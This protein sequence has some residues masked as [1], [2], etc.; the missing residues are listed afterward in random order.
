MERLN[1][2]NP[3]S[4]DM[5]SE[6]ETQ[7]PRV[8]F[9]CVSEEPTEESYFYGVRNNKVELNI[10]GDVK[11]HVIEKAEGQETLSH[12]LQLVMSCLTQ[13]GRIDE[14]GNPISSEK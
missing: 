13:M 9:Y 7:K 12:P 2:R 11:I 1:L 3:K 10:K 8:R 5:S 4:Y 6:S 14:E